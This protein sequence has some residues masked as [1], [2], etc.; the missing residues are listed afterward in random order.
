MKIE[1]EFEETQFLDKSMNIGNL[2]FND[3]CR[4]I[5]YKR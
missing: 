4:I 3:R 2:S 1:Q 5:E